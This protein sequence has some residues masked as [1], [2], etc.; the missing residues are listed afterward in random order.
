MPTETFALDHLVLA[1]QSLEEGARYIE[2]R[3][4]VRPR[5]GGHHPGVGTHNLLLALG[6]GSYLEIIAPD[7]NQA[8][9]QKPRPFGIDGEYQRERIS[10][11]PRLVHYILRCSTI[12]ESVKNA[13]YPLNPPIQM[14]RGKLSWDLALSNFD[15]PGGVQPMPSLIDWG[16]HEPPGFNLPAS[17]VLLQT[18]HVSAPPGETKC[19]VRVSTDPR[20]K[21]SPHRSPML[22]AEL[23][24][25]NGWAIL[26]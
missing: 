17:G 16:K 23:Q 1:A 2:Q 26:D 24:S 5:V 13:G 6:G 7:P 11:R 18:L 22:A 4:G 25:P 21:L 10:V 3:L 12:S 14:S 20:L 19:L 8:E 15:D 9:P